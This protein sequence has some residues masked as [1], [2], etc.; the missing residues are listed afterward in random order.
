MSNDEAFVPGSKVGDDD[1]KCYIPIF[2]NALDAR[3]DADTWY[4]GNLFTKKYYIA[5]D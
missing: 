2:R 5:F 1:S 3:G 4:L